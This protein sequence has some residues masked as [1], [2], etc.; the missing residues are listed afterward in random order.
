MD[1][2]KELTINY[3]SKESEV[4]MN[5]VKNLP[6]SDEV[7]I[8]E[9]SSK[10]LNENNSCSNLTND[11]SNAEVL[12]GSGEALIENMLETANDTLSYLVHCNTKP[13]YKKFTCY[14]KELNYILDQIHYYNDKIL[15]L[16]DNAEKLVS[17]IIG[18]LE[19]CLFNKAEILYSH[20]ETIK[21]SC[22]NQL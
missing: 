17:E 7:C 4:I 5:L 9:N 20:I 13:Y 22:N 16:V 21:Q 3:K 18:D 11:V 10:L 8:R 2:L 19:D 6:G 14:L 1:Q 12:I 15:A